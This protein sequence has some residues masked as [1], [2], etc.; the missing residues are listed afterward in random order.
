MS[1]LRFQCEYIYESG[2]RVS[3]E[4]ETS[5]LVTA[6]FGTSGSGKTT[7]L[8]LI[9]GLL[10]P[11]SGIIRLGDRVLTDIAGG[12]NVPPEQ[13]GIG[14]VFQDLYLFSHMSVRRNL[15]YGLR[16]AQT[17]RD[18]FSE[19]VELLEIGD[20][21][22]R[23]PHTLSGGQKQRVALGRALLQSPQLLL[24]DEP[25]A[26]LDRPLQDRILTYLKRV[27][28]RYELPTILVTHDR[29]HVETLTQSVIE[30]H[31]GQ[32]ATGPSVSADDCDTETE[33]ELVQR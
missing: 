16:R 28:D 17:S 9:A 23:P 6:L 14:L 26:A 10:R 31:D 25:L 15:E 18:N 27:L 33:D 7:V 4:F 1:Q 32:L 13:R 22:D 11:R 30:L 24:L 12:I 8:R 3:A 5:A 21:L 2:F 20:L 19:L 29:S